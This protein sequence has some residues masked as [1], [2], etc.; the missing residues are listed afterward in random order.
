MLSGTGHSSPVHCKAQACPHRKFLQ[1]EHSGIE[2]ETS[3]TMNFNTHTFY[4][5]SSVILV[6]SV[7]SD[8]N[9]GNIS[10]EFVGQFTLWCFPPLGEWV[11][12]PSLFIRELLPRSL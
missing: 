8:I 9:R 5:Y 6:Q 7:H 3:L 1:N 4:S 10:K 2:S 11:V 12:L